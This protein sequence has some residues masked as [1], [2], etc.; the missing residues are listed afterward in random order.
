MFYY[1]I[2]VLGNITSISDVIENI[3]DNTKG[4]IIQIEDL[5]YIFNYLK[6]FVCLIRFITRINYQY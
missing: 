2:D 4:I 1:F 5:K 3:K 6:I